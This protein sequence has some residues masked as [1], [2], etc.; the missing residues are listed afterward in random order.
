M[1]M[2][3]RPDKCIATGKAID[4]SKPEEKVRQE[5]IETLMKAYG[6]PKEYLDI[7][8]VIPMGSRSRY[9]D[10]AVYD[11]KGERDP[12]NNI[13]GII[14]TKAKGKRDGIAQLKS[15]MTASSARW[16]VWTNGDDIAYLCRQGLQIKDD[17]LNNIP[18]HGQSVDD[19]GQLE[20]SDLR[21]YSRTE[22]KSA[23]R[24]ILRTLYANANISRKEKLGNEMI[25]IIFAKLYDE[26]TYLDQPPRFRVQMGENP[27]DVAKRISGL[28]AEVRDELKDDGVFSDEDKITLPPKILAWVIGQLEKGNLIETE[29]DVVGDAFEEFSEAKLIGE[30]G[31]FFTPRNVVQLAV[32]LVDPKIGH[33]IC[34]PAC[35]SGG[36]LIHAMKHIAA[37]MRVSRKYRGAPDIEKK[38]STMAGKNFF[39]VDKESDLVRLAKAHMTIA[40]DGTSNI[41]YANSLNGTEEFESSHAGSY[42]VKSGKLREFDVVLTNP[43]FGT[44]NKV[45]VEEARKFKLGHKWTMEKKTSLCKQTGKEVQRDPYILFIE[46]CLELLKTGGTLAIVLPETVFHGK[47][48][49]YVRQFLMH[50]N[51]IRAIID[52][53]HNTFRPQ[54]NAKTC[55]LVL[56]KGREQQDFVTMAVPIEMGHDHKGRDLLRRGTG[57][58]WDD[59]AKVCEELDNDKDKDNEFVFKVPGT[60]LDPT[61]L[62]PK[63]YRHKQSLPAIPARF[64]GVLLGELVDAG[65]VEAWDGH[66]SPTAEEKGTGDIPYIRVADI[67]NWEMYRNPVAGIPKAEYLRVL[68]KGK[69]PKAG[70]V[71]F[72]R[73]GSY[74]IGTV[75]MASPR[76]EKVLLTKE[77]LTF[78]VSKMSNKH[79]ITPYYLLAALSS[80]IVQD[81][82][83]DLVFVDT[84]LPTIGHRWRRIVIPVPNGIKNAVKISKN[85]EQ[86]IKN[87]WK[88]AKAIHGMEADALGKLTC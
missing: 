5:Y 31:E 64:K 46:R 29:T 27:K 88:A 66:G 70:D 60:S 38:I 74:R 35:G 75:A 55:L 3:T 4:L 80:K 9:A 33:T 24:R 67:V 39:G 83:P 26:R 11:S 58:V 86:I 82:I 71:I 28:F 23:F 16:G 85:V 81:Q 43:P 63:Y 41:I 78:R 19:V 52:L 7:E 32:K 73:R 61:V 42:M 18:V 40:G 21:P 68:G 6:Y 37:A 87:K 77:L 62:V 30:R 36:F 47:S 59:I 54:C 20:R 57:E 69:P 1:N 45:I 2:A 84:T 17:R 48:L 10:I 79:G 51:N 8:V 34:D 72:V 13:I 76:D 22:I 56:E 25:K 50:K 49:Q 15:Y 44:K 12:A 65:V 14:E 53:P